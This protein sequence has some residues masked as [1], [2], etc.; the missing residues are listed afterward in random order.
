M[1]RKIGGFI[2][3]SA[4][5]IVL[6]GCQSNE[7]IS[8]ILGADVSAAKVISGSDSHGGFHGD[9][10]RYME[11]RFED[12]TFENTIKKD[13]TW[14][15][16]PVKDDSIE[17]LLYGKTMGSVAYGPYLQSEMPHIEEGYYF[18]YDRHEE[19]ADPFDPSNVLGR[20]SMNFKVAL[21]DTEKDILYFAELDT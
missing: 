21:Y 3:I 13:N 2:A 8:L 15:A 12:D 4:I 1:L 14:H 18:F 20:A 9:G 10:E 5:L 17:A 7:D 11:F 19:S 6:A 16:L